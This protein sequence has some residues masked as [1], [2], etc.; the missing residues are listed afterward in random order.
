M[1]YYSRGRKYRY[2]ITLLNFHPRSNSL[3]LDIPDDLFRKGS[4]ATG[5]MLN[6]L[7]SDLGKIYLKN[8]VLPMIRQVEDLTEDMVSIAAMTSWMS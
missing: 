7:F 6:F 8:T 2:G 1:V 5:V 4:I 3:V